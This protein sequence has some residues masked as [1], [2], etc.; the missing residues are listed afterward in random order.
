MDKTRGLSFSLSPK[1]KKC[2]YTLVRTPRTNRPSI[3]TAVCSHKKLSSSLRWLLLLFLE[4]TGQTRKPI[5]QGVLPSL[6]GATLFT[7]SH[8]LG[9]K[10]KS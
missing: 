4:M 8:V 9:T 5:F 10:R 6:L 7:A 2:G 3:P 1:G